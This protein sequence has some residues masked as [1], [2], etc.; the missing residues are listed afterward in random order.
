[1]AELA[2]ASLAKSG[3]KKK[4]DYQHVADVVSSSP[5]FSFLK[6]IIPHRMT[7]RTYLRI[8]KRV[9]VREQD[10]GR[11]L[12]QKEIDEIRRSIEEGGESRDSENDDD[13]QEDEAVDDEEEEEEEGDEDQEEEMEESED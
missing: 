10:L 9:E 13:E 1:M 4:L 7:A 8:L 2:K 11:Y 3:G 6:D 5:P 12:V